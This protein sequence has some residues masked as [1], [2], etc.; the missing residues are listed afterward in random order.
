MTVQPVSLKSLRVVG[1]GAGS[2]VPAYST[3]RAYFRSLVTG[4][5]TTRSLPLCC[6]STSFPSR[7]TFAT[8]SGLPRSSWN[9]GAVAVARKARVVVPVSVEESASHAMSRW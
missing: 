3:T 9:S 5:F 4:A 8:S 6:D 7:V 2:G 1:A